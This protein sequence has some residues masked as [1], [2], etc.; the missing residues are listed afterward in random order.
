MH[1][2]KTGWLIALLSLW[3]SSLQAGDPVTAD[4]Q[5]IFGVVESIDLERLRL[6]INGESFLFEPQGVRNG[7]GG[8]RIRLTDLQIWD[9]VEFTRA[10][11]QPGERQPRLATLVIIRD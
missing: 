5:R 7:V 11:E 9:Y 2:I 6:R 4:N 1:S 10:T 3:G 8:K